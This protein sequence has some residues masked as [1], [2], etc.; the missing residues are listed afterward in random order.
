MTVRIE[1]ILDGVCIQQSEYTINLQGTFYL[2]R[3]LEK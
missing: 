3:E 2:V 1:I